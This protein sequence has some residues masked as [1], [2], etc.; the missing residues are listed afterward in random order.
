MPNAVQDRESCKQDPTLEAFWG[1]AVWPGV[2][3]S[4]R[5]YAERGPGAWRRDPFL[6]M[7]EHGDI[8][9][10]PPGTYAPSFAMM[11]LATPSLSLVSAMRSAAARFSGSAFFMATPQPAASIIEMSLMLSPKDTASATSSP[12]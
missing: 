6:R 7:F 11:T 4:T 3:I 12:R 5:G 1:L 10:G 2:Y 8:Y 9:A